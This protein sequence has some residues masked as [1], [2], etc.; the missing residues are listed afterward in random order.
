MISFKKYSPEYVFVSSHHK[1][2]PYN[3]KI[4]EFKIDNSAFNEW[5][6]SF[7]W[8][9]NENKK[10]EKED[11]VR[12]KIIIKEKFLEIEIIKTIRHTSNL[13][14]L[15]IINV[16]YVS[17]SSQNKLSVIEM[18]DIYK[19]F[20]KFLILFY[21]KSNHFKAFRIKCLSCGEWFSLYYNKDFVNENNSDYISFD[22]IDIKKD[23]NKILQEWYL[24]EDIQFC[25][26]IILGNILSIKVSH[27][28]RFTNSLAS[29]EAFNKR[30]GAN[31]KNPTVEKYFNDL[32]YIF[33]EIM[34]IEEE[35][36]KSFVKKVIRTRDYYVHGNKTQVNIFSKFDLLY[37]S[38]LID[39]VIGVELSKQLGFSSENI[40][41]IIN[42]ATSVYVLMQSTNRILD[43][44]IL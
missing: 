4:K 39:F 5:I 14:S 18:I 41:D 20:Q 6:R 29:F 38:F 28:R 27:S 35:L 31:H 42:K 33:I 44:N 19:T 24:N 34:I 11:D 21:G 36:Y 16:G 1:I 26:D 17:F 23:L 25:S 22:Y 9:D 8:Y 40:K 10:L 13:N 3:L 32:K 15:N 43:K 12:H 37:I 7:H 2:D 30:F